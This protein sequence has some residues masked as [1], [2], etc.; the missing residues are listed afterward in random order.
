MVIK[1]RYVNGIECVKISD[2]LTKNT[3]DEET[4]RAVKKIFGLPI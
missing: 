2:D 4:V 3:G 1:L